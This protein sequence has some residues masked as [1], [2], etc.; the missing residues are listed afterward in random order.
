MLLNRLDQHIQQNPGPPM[1]H[2]RVSYRVGWFSS[3]AGT[4]SQD[5]INDIGTWIAPVGQYIG[6]ALD[7]RVTGI[8]PAKLADAEEEDVFL[9]LAVPRRDETKV[10]A[11]RSSG[12]QVRL[13]AAARGHPSEERP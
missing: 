4:C 2:G 1:A 11:D 3:F 13:G 8:A 10:I 5:Q 6:H 7:S 9:L 12:S